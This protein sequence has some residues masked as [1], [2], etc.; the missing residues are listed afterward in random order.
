VAM[1][2]NKKL[3]VAVNSKICVLRILELFNL[4]FNA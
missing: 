1:L 2:S 4:I 3:V